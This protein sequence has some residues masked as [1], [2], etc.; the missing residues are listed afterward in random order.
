MI[1]DK[2][3][4]L[5]F[6]IKIENDCEKWL[7]RFYKEGEYRWEIHSDPCIAILL[8][9]ELAFKELYEKAA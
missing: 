4:E 3:K 6:F 5:G 9:A 8:A 2:M 7:V 1:I